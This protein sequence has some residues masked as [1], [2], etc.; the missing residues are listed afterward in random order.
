MPVRKILSLSG[1][2]C[3]GLFQA[4]FLK[5]LEER[6]D[7]DL[8]NVFDLIAG[9]STGSIVGLAI[10]LGIKTEEIE[11]MYLDNACKIF[12]R[13]RLRFIKEF[14]RGPIYDQCELRGSLKSIFRR[15]KLRDVKTPVLITATKE[16]SYSHHIFSSHDS[17]N[18]LELEAVDIALA[19]SAAP[20]YFPPVKPSGRNNSFI[21][22]GVWAN[23]PSLIAVLYAKNVLGF[24]FDSLRVLSIDTGDFPRRDHTPVKELRKY[25]LKTVKAMLDMFHQT[26]SSFVNNYTKD[27]IGADQYKRITFNIEKSLSL[28]N[29][30]ECIKHLPGIAET[31]AEEHM[32]EIIEFM[33]S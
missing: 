27:L 20:T 19:S 21:D 6:I 24:N 13:R 15:D 28:D 16:H 8:H 14:R 3:R 12:P 33:K 5:K 11:K 17:S 2:G 23:S 26:Q 32:D 7:D 4:S 1:G 10:A 18:D 31:Q 25:S 30:M 9:T 22:G 29:A